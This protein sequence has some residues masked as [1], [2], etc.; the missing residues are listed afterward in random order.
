MAD[1]PNLPWLPGY[2]PP[3]VDKGLIDLI[4]N[5]VHQGVDQITDIAEQAGVPTVIAEP[6]KATVD[7]TVDAGTKVVQSPTP[8]TIKDA[9][10]DAAATS[11]EAAL[12][13]ILPDIKKRVAETVE[14]QVTEQLSKSLGQP[15]T[16]ELG[17]LV[18]ADARSR[19]WRTLAGGLALSVLYGIISVFGDLAGINWFSKEG[20]ATAASLVV[21][22]V[23]GSVLAYVARLIKEPAP[24]T[25]A[26]NTHPV[27][28]PGA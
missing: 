17:D 20:L 12:E 1:Q 16:V 5:Q 7:A 14:K 18:K 23:V 25:E 8:Q 2:V 22:S 26:L 3:G 10:K 27:P 4:S 21:F 9:V 11:A 19:A 13:S 6:V 28:P 15:K 24:F